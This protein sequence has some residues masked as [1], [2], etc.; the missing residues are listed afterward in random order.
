[1]AP[2]A[3]FA[4]IA[5]S[6]VGLAAAGNNGRAVKP[7]MGW[8]SWNVYAGNIDQS[9]MEATADAMA[10]RV[11]TVDGKPTSLADLG[12]N[13]VGLD[14]NWQLAGSYGPEQ[15]TYH[16]A[17]GYPQINP[18]RF[19]D[20]KAMVDAIHALGLTSGWYGNNCIARDHCS[21][22]DCFA[23]DVAA[24]IA[25][26]FDS[27]KLDGCGA[28][29]DLQKWWDLFEASGKAVMVENCHWG[30]TLP[31]A[32]WCPWSYYRSSGDVRATYSSIVSNLNTVFPLATQNLSTP[33]CWAY[34]DMLEVG[35]S[36]LGMSWTEWRSHFAAWSIVSSPLIL[37]LN[38]TNTSLLQSV[39]PIIANPESI[40]VN[41]AYFGHSGNLFK[42]SPTSVSL[43]E[44]KGKEEASS[45]LD[46]ASIQRRKVQAS[47]GVHEA[48]C[49]FPSWQ[50]L[51][52][53]IDAKSTAVLLMNH[54]PTT[55][56]L[57]VNWSDVPNLPCSPTVSPGSGC[58]VR[59]IHAR[60]DLGTYRDSFTV[61][62]AS[63]DSAFLMLI[64]E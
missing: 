43:C 31:N 30:L 39:W 44:D 34:P 14:D 33:S 11:F 62:L 35:V 2:L 7:P 53:P 27:T 59:D 8:R 36:L 61:T 60:V 10:A 32:T 6:T 20:M 15:Y 25:L 54:A 40:A 57:T 17:T 12:Y 41:Q 46:A 22:D 64:D 3:L 18:A 21:A 28:E 42:A 45:A 52:K 16:N 56:T 58:L 51:Y 63:H 50:Y 49:D 9:I 23:S 13:D 24:T 26:G 4:A 38:V 55:Q 5:A 47:R 19:P 48:G 1:M 37:G 29:L